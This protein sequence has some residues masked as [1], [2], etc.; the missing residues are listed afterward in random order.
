[1]LQRNSQRPMHP[2]TFA[3]DLCGAEARHDSVL[4]AYAYLLCNRM[5][6]IIANVC[7]A[8]TMPLASIAG[9]DRP[10]SP[11]EPAKDGTRGV[12]EGS[13]KLPPTS[14]WRGRAPREG[15]ME[16]HLVRSNIGRLHL[17]AVASSGAFRQ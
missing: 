7:N 1:M 5:H 13:K 10:G 3:H 12:A 2:R 11:S 14:Q 17:P 15:M 9:H 8:G 6:K 4:H 16:T